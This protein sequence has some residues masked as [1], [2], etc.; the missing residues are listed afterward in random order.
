[1]SENLGVPKLIWTSVI[2]DY[3]LNSFLMNGFLWGR[4]LIKKALQA[5]T[6]QAK[7]FAVVAI[8]K[9]EKLEPLRKR[10]SGAFHFFC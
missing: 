3:Y 4:T 7:S 8:C 5:R 10:I 1:M 2:R 6:K 9:L